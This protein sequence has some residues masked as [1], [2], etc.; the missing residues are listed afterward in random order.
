MKLLIIRHGN[1]DYA[2]DTLTEKGW[3][4]A[5]ALAERLK[6]YHIDAIYTSPLGRAKD[7]ARPTVEVTGIQ[8]VVLDWLREFP[9]GVKTAYRPGGMCPWEMRPLHWSAR[10]GLCDREEWKT[11]EPFAESDCPA[12]FERVGESF[13]ALMAEYGYTRDGDV[14]RMDPEKAPN[15]KTIAFFCHQG[16]GLA[17]FSHIVGLSPAWVWQTMF[18]PTSSVTEVHMETHR[19]EPGIA[20]ARVMNLGDISHL[21]KRNF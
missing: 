13:N 15:D 4:E 21:D 18:L 3:A 20:A 14:Y 10:P 1:P 19:E 12:V 7:T 2:N 6:D 11:S 9:A 8:P 5:H 16:L 17:L